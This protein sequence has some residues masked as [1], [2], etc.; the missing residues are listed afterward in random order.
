[1]LGN[2]RVRPT[3][4][5]RDQVTDTATDHPPAGKI[6]PE[7]NARGQG[8]LPFEGL[9][10][11]RGEYC[12]FR[13]EREILRLMQ[14]DTRGEREIP[15]CRLTLERLCRST[16]DRVDNGQAAGCGVPLDERYVDDQVQAPVERRE[17]REGAEVG[18]ALRIVVEPLG[19]R[20]EPQPVKVAV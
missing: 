9:V 5:E 11:G 2:Q 8:G 20:E 10:A 16:R 7:G 19:E 3:A 4:L 6:V 17:D 13:C 15:E 14:Q 1:E 18:V 12:E